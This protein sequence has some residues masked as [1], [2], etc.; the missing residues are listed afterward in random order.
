M[1]HNC[2]GICKTGPR[3]M[4]SVIDVAVQEHPRAR[5]TYLPG[6]GADGYW[7]KLMECREL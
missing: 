2:S 6:T 7:C 4:P 5:A 1:R 3:E